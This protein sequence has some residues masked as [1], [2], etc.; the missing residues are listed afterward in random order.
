MFLSLFW[1]M[2]PC[3]AADK[4]PDQQRAEDL[5]NEKTDDDPT[6]GTLGARCLLPLPSPGVWVAYVMKDQQIS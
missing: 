3:R 2:H 5:T 4:R 1:L 6:A